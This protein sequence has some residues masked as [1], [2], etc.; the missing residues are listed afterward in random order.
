MAIC[1]DEA[2]LSLFI[3]EAT[4]VNPDHP[5]LVDKFIEDAIEVDADAL[6]D[7]DE[8]FIGG[9]MEH[10]EMAGVHSGDSAMSLPHF[11][12][13]DAQVESIRKATVA[14]ARELDVRGLMNVQYAV[15]GSTVFVLEVNPRASRTVPFVSKAIGIPLAKVAAKIMVGAKL[16]DFGL[17]KEIEP[18]HYSV[19]ESVFPFKKFSGV[20]I[21][22]GPEM[23]STGEVMGIDADFGR[24]YLKAEM[25]ASHRLPRKGT[26]F[27]SVKDS[28]KRDVVHLAKRLEDLGFTLVATGGT[29]KVLE[30]HGI[31]VRRVFKIKDGSRPNA[32][33]LIINHELDLVINSPSG[34]G[35]K[36]DEGRIR[37][38][39]VSHGIHVITSIAGAQAA[40][41]GIESLLRKP[42]EVRA[43]QDYHPNYGSPAAKHEALV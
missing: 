1:Y 8:V 29:A 25:G 22:L 42:L 32:I 15:K 17:I 40:V 10:I 41:N 14:L 12:L 19:K 5:V 27:V 36:T 4:E 28:D 38:F 6:A 20:D 35:A 26:I 23:K 16:R 11:S 3:R 39:A 21:I 24:A 9:I 7:G 34:K 43:I 13:S 33:D 2:D 37:A 30:R 18:R 31:N